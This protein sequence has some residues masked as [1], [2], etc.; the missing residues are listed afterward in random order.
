VSLCVA[1][2]ASAQ[3]VVAGL[4]AAEPAVVAGCWLGY[5]LVAASVC[6]Y[7]V[8]VAQL[9]PPLPFVVA[10]LFAAAPPLPLA[11]II[12][13]FA[14]SLLVALFAA[15]AVAALTCH[16]LLLLVAS[17]LPLHPVGC[18]CRRAVIR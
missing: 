4:V 16:L 8:A 1:F 5:W 11:A 13:C 9:L 2:Q 3:P 17:L 10:L 7:W 14:V 15:A 12:G 18:R 6:C